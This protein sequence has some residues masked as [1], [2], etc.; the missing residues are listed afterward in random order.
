MDLKNNNEI[1]V[2]IKGSLENFYKILEKKNY[3]ILD[4]FFLDDTYF[5]P[6]ELDIK[7]MSVRDILSK[8]VLVRNINNEIYKECKKKIVFK[9]KKFNEKG[10]ILKQDSVN[11]DIVNIDDAKKLLNAIGYKEI[12]NIKERDIVYGKNEIQL[13]VKDIV[14]GENLIEIETDDKDGMRTVEEL[15]VTLNNLDIPVENNDYFIKKA[16]IELNKV[17]K[18]M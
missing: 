15:K 4:K 9:I 10:E 1:T 5:V 14:D 18:K 16:E 11:C 6:V 12:M 7:K 13:A 3:K 8:A 2:R 17:L